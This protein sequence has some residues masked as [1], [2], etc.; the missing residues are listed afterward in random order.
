ADGGT[1]FLDEIGEVPIGLQAKL[2]RA[3][4]TSSV[5]PVG[6]GAERKIDVRI[7]AAT[8]R[9]LARAV[10]EKKFREDLYY[11]LHVIP[12]H[13]PPLRARREDIPLLVEHFAARV[14]EQ[15]PDQAPREITSEVMR[16]LI[17]LPWPGNVRELKNAVERLLLLARGKRVDVRDLALAVPEQPP[18]AMAAL[19]NEIVPLRVMTRRYVEWVLAQ[20]NGNKVR[21]AQLL[22]ID[23]STIYRMLSREDE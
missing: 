13:L 3:I 2:L 15:H 21:T 23:A 1:L 17:E 12:V 20:T 22:G 19:A 16:R 4:E 11:R 7:V 5:R 14:A 6:G 8:N 10:Q 9:D 18:E